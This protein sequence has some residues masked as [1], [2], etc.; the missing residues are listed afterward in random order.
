QSALAVRDSDSVQVVPRGVPIVQ[1]DE[2]DVGVLL[3]HIV[4]FRA[5]AA[6]VGQVSRGRDLLVRSHGVGRIHRPDVVVLVS[7]FVLNKED[8]AGVTTPDVTRYRS[9]QIGGDRSR[10]V[11]RFAGALHPNISSALVGFYER[12][13]LSVGRQ[14]AVDD[15]GI[16]KEKLSIKNRSA[17]VSL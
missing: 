15:F 12:D 7:G 6:E 4:E 10:L 8:V 9:L 5:H 11:K 13:E 17:I 16:S 3:R 1:P 2:Y 14:F